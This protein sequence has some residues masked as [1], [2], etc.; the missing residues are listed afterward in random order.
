LE[1]PELHQQ[2]LPRY[3][4]SASGRFVGG[5]NTYGYVYGNPTGL[6]DPTGNSPFA[7]VTTVA[8]IASFCYTVSKFNDALSKSEAGVI[9]SQNMQ[10]EMQRWIDAG[11]KGD[12]PY[13]QSQIQDAQKGTLN[14]TLEAAK[15]G[16]QLTPAPLDWTGKILRLLPKM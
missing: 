2:N 15:N 9:N 7:V 1:I 6:T 3:D 5:F 16:Q 14:D 12:P 4:E 8:A 11:M 10:A 13:S